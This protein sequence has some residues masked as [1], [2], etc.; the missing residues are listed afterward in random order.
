M[1][2]MIAFWILVVSLLSNEIGSAVK[3]GFYSAIHFPI[4][5]KYIYSCPRLKKLIVYSTGHI[6]PIPTRRQSMIKYPTYARTSKHK[7][8][9]S[10]QFVGKQEILF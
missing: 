10:A 1:E 4:W 9:F 6:S 2:I 7:R 3:H 8:I 5:F